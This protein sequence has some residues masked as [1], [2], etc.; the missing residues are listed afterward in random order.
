[1]GR[2]RTKTSKQLPERWQKKHGAYYYIVPDH[3][4]H[5]FDDKKWF[6]LGTTYPEALRNFADRKELDTGESMAGACDRFV[7]DKL[8]RYKPQTQ[9]SYK[10]AV[11]R[12]KKGLGQN[13]TGLIRPQ[14]VYQYMEFVKKKHGVNS[15]N[16]D[17]K[18]MNTVLDHSV[19]IGVIDRNPI[20]GE[21]KYYGKRDGAKQ[22]RER[23]VE[24]WELAEWRQVATP[25]QLA[26]AAICMLT[27]A[28]KSDILRIKRSDIK[29]GHLAIRHAKTNKN[30]LFVITPALRQAI[31]YALSLHRKPS[32]WLLPNKTGQCYVNDQDATKS[33]DQGWQRSMKRAIEQTKLEQTF[34]RHDLRAKVG[35]DAETDERAQQLLGH[36][37]VSMTKKHYRRR[38]PIL[39]PTR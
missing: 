35:S 18:V 24:D 20:K 25:V 4:R 34:T 30:V 10:R 38:V 14:I 9:Q 11:D 22:E 5:I 39:S 12:I 17:L 19:R 15:A 3:E 1:M 2:K 27:G 8:E 28:R 21:V 6:R 31:D 36:T 37:S 23:Y 13:K 29:D 32:F 33:F 16:I 7:M 26:F